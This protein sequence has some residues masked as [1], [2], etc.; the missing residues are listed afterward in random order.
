MH[1]QAI[2]TAFFL[3]CTGCRCILGTT[4]TEGRARMH[5]ESG[6]TQRGVSEEPWVVREESRVHKAYQASQASLASLAH[7]DPQ[8]SPDYREP[9]DPRGHREPRAPPDHGAEAY[10]ENPERQGHADDGAP[11]DHEAG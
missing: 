2:S 10:R 3:F 9:P 5:G 6:R 8:A 4:G 7:R 11:P 1:L